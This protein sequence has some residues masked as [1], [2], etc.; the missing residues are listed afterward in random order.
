M[1]KKSMDEMHYEY[2]D[3]KNILTIVKKL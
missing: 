2:A 1:V 3:G